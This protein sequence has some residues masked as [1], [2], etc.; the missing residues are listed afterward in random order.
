M[1]AKGDEKSLRQAD[2]MR[3]QYDYNKVISDPKS[4]PEQKK[5]AFDKMVVAS[6]LAYRRDNNVKQPVL[7]LPPDWAATHR[8]QKNAKE[9]ELLVQVGDIDNLGFGWPQKFDPF[10]GKS[11]PIASL[12]V[13]ARSRRSAG[14]RSHHGQYR[15]AGAWSA[16]RMATRARPIAPRISRSR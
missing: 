5:A 2:M 4:T 16:A 6:K 15:R 14:H 12:S 3:A 13:G 8:E 1:A 7:D 10:A 9:A 11:T